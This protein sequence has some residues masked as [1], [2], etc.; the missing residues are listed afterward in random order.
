MNGK[1]SS[2]ETD[3]IPVGLLRRA[4]A[5][6]VQE[7]AIGKRPAAAAKTLDVLS[8]EGGKLPEASIQPKPGT[9]L[10]REWNGRI[11]S[12]IMRDDGFEF[13]GKLYRSFVERGPQIT[14]AH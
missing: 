10:V 14:G 7:D 3:G 11:H 2:S 8:K 12:V 1:R 9:R 5:Y 6:R 13:D 4:I